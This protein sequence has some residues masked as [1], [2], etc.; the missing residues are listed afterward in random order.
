VTNPTSQ[1]YHRR[2]QELTKAAS[3]SHFPQLGDLLRW[4]AAEHVA[5]AHA[6]EKVPVR[7]RRTPV[8]PVG[9]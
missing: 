2:A 6:L 3:N 4:S 1:Q 8:S 5:M 7:K 9:V